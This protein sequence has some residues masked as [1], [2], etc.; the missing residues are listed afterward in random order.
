VILEFGF[1]IGKLGRERVCALK[2]PGVDEPS[3]IRGVL[4]IPLDNGGA[5]RLKLAAELKAANIDVDLN[6]AV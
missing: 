5:W 2:T 6:C 4:Y 1:F 3:D